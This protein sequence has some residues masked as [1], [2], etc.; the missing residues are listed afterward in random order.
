MS[1]D[2][3]WGITL[4]QKLQ[5]RAATPPIKQEYEEDDGPD[6]QDEIP[7]GYSP[8]RRNNPIQEAIR[9]NS[10]SA[11]N[12][13]TGPP[14]NKQPP[15]HLG[16]SAKSTAAT[17]GYRPTSGNP[18][19]RASEYSRLDQ[20]FVSAAGDQQADIEEGFD[21]MNLSDDGKATGGHVDAW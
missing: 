12:Q 6:F 5:T 15:S 20:Y 18:V 1:E 14:Q 7:A 2:D 19:K 3:G 11:T 13:R 8:G 17:P 16:R 9:S 10:G 21:G 4:P